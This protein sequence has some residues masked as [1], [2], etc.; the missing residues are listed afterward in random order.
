MI[1]TRKSVFLVASTALL[2]VGTG[3][4]TKRFVRA[5]VA[6]VDARLGQVETAAKQNTADIDQLEKQVSQVDETASG[7]GQEA[8]SAAELARQAGTRAGEA[9]SRAQGAYSLAEEGISKAA[10]NERSIDR[11]YES[12]DNFALLREESVVFAFDRAE[13]TADAKAKLDALAAA[14]TGQ[15]RYVIEV[16]G[17][18]DPAGNA[19]YNEELS[20]RRATAVV[21]YLTLS[22]AIPL[23]RIQMLG[24]GAE[25]PVADN[26][27]RAGRQQ[28]RRVE[29]KVYALPDA[30][31]VTRAAAAARSL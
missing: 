5:S 18:A 14:L 2:L 30:K 17:F 31:A 13:L 9:G 15:R 1:M 8:K 23:R 24:V 29:V 26:R 21:R 22:R 27:T 11:M 19:A 16:Q 25:Q 3:C 7:A 12:L 28:N 4:A 10:A 20:R 6:P